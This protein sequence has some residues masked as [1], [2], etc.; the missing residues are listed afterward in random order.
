MINTCVFQF[1]SIQF[2]M[3]P[4]RPE[5]GLTPVHPPLALGPFQTV[6]SLPSRTDH[7][8]LYYLTR[9][10]VEVQFFL[11]A[12][13]LSFRLLF[14]TLETENFCENGWTQIP[15]REIIKQEI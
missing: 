1:K 5:T 14:L 4:N 7:G 6:K 2:P 13:L 8:M 9:C 12:A 15:K 11:F 10:F 3:G